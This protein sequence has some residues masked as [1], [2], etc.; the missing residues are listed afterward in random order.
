MRVIGMDIHRSFARVA[1]LDQGEVTT[2]KRVEL[3]HDKVLAFGKTL[4]PDDEVVI[5]ATGN[6]AAVERLLR[7]FVGRVII[8]NPRMVRAIAYA[9]VKTD[10][11]DAATL[12]RLQASGFLP[13]VWAS[14]DETLRRGVRRRSGWASSRRQSAS[15]RASTQS[16]MR[17]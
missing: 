9:R 8:A 10:K 15:S 6:T 12:A 7:P 3:V 2:E 13:E 14:E 4:R 17:A 1:I 5:E 16:C 11:I